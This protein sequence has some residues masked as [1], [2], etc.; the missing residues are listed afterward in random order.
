MDFDL[1]EEQ[2]LLQNSVE[3]LVADHYPFE[4]RQQTVAEPDGW[5]R[6]TWERFAEIGILGLPFEEQ[7]GGFGGGPV[8][9][10][11]VVEA[12]GRGLVVEP[13]IPTV[14]FAGGILRRSGTRAQQAELCPRIASGETM[15]AVAHTEPTSRYSR[16]D[17]QATA[18][19]D[20]NHW[21]LNGTKTVVHG[22]GCADRLIVSARTAGDRFDRSG[23]GLFLVDGAAA[24]VTRQSYEIHD[25]RRAATLV[26]DDVRLDADAV[27]GDPRAGFE[28]LDRALDETIAASCA[29]CVGVLAEAFDLTVEYLQTREQ[30]GVPIGSFQA[31]QHRVVDMLMVLE[32]SRSMALYATLMVDTDDPLER[33]R[34][35]AAAKA[36]LSQ[37]ARSV[38]QESVQ[39][40]GG[41]AI[42]WEYKISHYFKHL[43]MFE[44]EWG[45]EQHHTREVATAGGLFGRW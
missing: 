38:G 22:G 28:V 30:F 13:Y 45:D 17:V 27:I 7:F 19:E 16:S 18:R 14:V 26:L 41:I 3:R 23:I 4:F 43:S 15:L 2:R 5:S 10:M 9:T 11:V 44:I 34:A 1:T 33:H 8:D 40:H 36:Y 37:A 42:T 20:G 24:G 29:Q 6:K 21:V 39:L 35:V 25:G 31:L 32:Q 12:L